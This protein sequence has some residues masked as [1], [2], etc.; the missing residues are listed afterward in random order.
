MPKANPELLAELAATLDRAAA[1]LPHV[2][3]KKMF[4][5]HALFAKDAVFGLVWKEGRLGVRL[6]EEAPFGKLMAM[7]G[8][9]PWRAGPMT[10]SHWVL[11]PPGMHAQP[12][13]LKDWVRS[14][15]ELALTVGAA[16]KT[17]KKK[18]G[19]KTAKPKAAKAKTA[20]PK[21]AK[22]KAAKR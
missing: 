2:T 10:M 21:A 12:A 16:E 17:A 20:K 13:K 14:A 6:P 19:A 15:H 22:A 3:A 9:A 7:T 8:A 1:D 4:G 5:C 11:V 18:A